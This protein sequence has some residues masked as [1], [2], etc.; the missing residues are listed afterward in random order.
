[1]EI[2]GGAEIPPA[3]CYAVG[4]YTE[5]AVTPWKPALQQ[6]PG[7][8][9]ALM[10]TGAHTGAYFLAGL[11]SLQGDPCWS[12]MFLKDCTTWKGHML[13]EFVKNCSPREGEAPMV[14]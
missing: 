7:R 12:S 3:A 9:C 11:V 5:E 14:E 8:T 2:C 13:E 4:G 10:E 1:M 6:A